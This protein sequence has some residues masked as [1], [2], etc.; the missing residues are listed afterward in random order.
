MLQNTRLQGTVRRQTPKTETVYKWC[1]SVSPKRKAACLLGLYEVYSEMQTASSEGNCLKHLPTTE[2][3]LNSASTTKSKPVAPQSH[4]CPL[5]TRL[6][7]ILSWP[8]LLLSF[9]DGHLH[10]KKK[11]LEGKYMGKQ[12]AFFCWCNGGSSMIWVKSW[13]LLPVLKAGSEFST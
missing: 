3:N 5:A 9:G 10:L 8:F 7:E 13:V 2:K 1:L 11:I 4:Q 6:W 12:A